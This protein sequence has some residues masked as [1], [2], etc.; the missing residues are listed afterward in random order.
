MGS[1]YEVE[2]IARGMIKYVII[3]LKRI[4]A[5]KSERIFAL[6]YVSS[7]DKRREWSDV[8]T[9]AEKSLKLLGRI[10]SL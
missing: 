4:Y 8:I 9:Y 10:R 6:P 3:M 2:S 5:I 1:L 7:V